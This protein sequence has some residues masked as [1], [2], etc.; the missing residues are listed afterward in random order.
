MTTTTPEQ[1]LVGDSKYAQAAVDGAD[2]GTKPTENVVVTATAP[3]SP[4]AV[5]SLQKEL[6][7]A[8]AGVQGVA[9]VGEPAVSPDGRTLLVGVEMNARSSENPDDPAQKALPTTDE[10]VGP[11]MKVTE[12]LAARHPDLKIGQIG[13]GSVNAEVNSARRMSASRFCSA[14]AR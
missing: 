3:L 1:Q 8:Y 10:A 4:E 2:F 14:S 13:E 11:M 12:T 6:S 9:S 7:Q 5:K